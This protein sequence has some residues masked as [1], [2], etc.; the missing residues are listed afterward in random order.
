MSATFYSYNSNFVSQPGPTDGQDCYIYTDHYGVND[1]TL[2]F[3]RWPGLGIVWLSL[4]RFDIGKIPHTAYSFSATLTLY[5]TGDTI[6]I[7]HPK[8]FAAELLH[9]DS[10]TEAATYRTYDGR[11]NWNALGGDV[12]PN[13]QAIVTGVE[14]TDDSVTI[15][16]STLIEHAMQEHGTQQNRY[17]DLRIRDLS[18][19]STAIFYAHSSES[20]QESRRPKLEVNY[21]DRHLAPAIE[22]TVNLSRPQFEYTGTK[23]NEM[24]TVITP[25]VSLPETSSVDVDG[26][27][28][29][30]GDTFTAYGQ[31]ARY[32][33]DTYGIGYAPSD[34]A[35]LTVVNVH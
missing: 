4:L 14:P 17:L 6:L 27:R 23:T 32:L 18:G 31:K 29:K 15:D 8:I 20:S 9:N 12:H 25:L 19:L 22:F 16:V 2:K 10:W 28:L 3:G 30:H 33:R 26:T 34:R 5:N 13:L 7:D 1:G 11:T 24:L 21:D 35:I